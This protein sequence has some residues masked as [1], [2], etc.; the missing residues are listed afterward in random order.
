[1]AKEP[2]YSDL[3][4]DHFAKIDALFMKAVNDYVTLKADLVKYIATEVSK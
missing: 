4:K 1:M 3:L 2:K